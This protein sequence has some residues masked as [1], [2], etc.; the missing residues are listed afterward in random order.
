VKLLEEFVGTKPDR[1][2]KPVAVRR[3]EELR[4]KYGI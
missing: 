1:F 4:K 3:I 2:L